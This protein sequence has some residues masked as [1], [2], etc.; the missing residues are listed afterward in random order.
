MIQE[1][2]QGTSRKVNMKQGREPLRRLVKEVLPS[3]NEAKAQKKKPIRIP[4]R[5]GAGGTWKMKSHQPA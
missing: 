5:G 3:Q 1:E 2:K 4:A